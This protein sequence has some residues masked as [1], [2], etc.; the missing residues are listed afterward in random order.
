MLLR[1]LVNNNHTILYT[2][3]QPSAQL[4]SMFDRLLL[5]QDGATLY[6]GDIGQGASVLT[7]Y[8]ETKGA[9]RCLPEEN[10]AE[11]MLDVTTRQSVPSAD[12]QSWPS[13]WQMSHEREGVVVKLKSLEA[14]RDVSP[15]A[16]ERA[17]HQ[18]KGEFAAPLSQQIILLVERVFQDQWRN[19]L[20]LYTKTAVCIGLVR[21]PTVKIR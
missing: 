12:N 4:F 19:P 5:L 15:T 16:A 14:G 11:W 8:F 9:R 20:Y 13:K 6:F 17:S 7:H 1:K 3:H 2:I 10:P 18:G 21:F